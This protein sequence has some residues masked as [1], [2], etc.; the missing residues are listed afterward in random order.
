MSYED[1]IRQNKLMQERFCSKIC[2]KYECGLIEAIAKEREADL[3]YQI[4]LENELLTSYEN[5]LD[6]LL[7]KQAACTELKK[8][9][10]D[11]MNSH[12]ENNPQWDYY[13]KE[14]LKF[15]DLPKQ[16][17]V[18][19]MNLG[20]QKKIVEKAD[21]GH[22]LN[23]NPSESNIKS[24]FKY[25]YYKDIW[26]GIEHWLPDFVTQVFDESAYTL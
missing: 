1:M 3:Q 23:Y 4:K 2:R 11:K 21:Y 10:T 20:K 16:I 24:W 26:Q 8:E 22:L 19:R 9:L 13:R 15:D 14:L 18:A 17:K 5:N 25:G 7:A 6:N 12:V